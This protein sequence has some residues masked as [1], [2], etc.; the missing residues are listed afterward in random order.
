MRKEL[1]LPLLVSVVALCAGLGAAPAELEGRCKALAPRVEQD[2]AAFAER[3]QHSG[4]QPTVRELT[5]CAWGL[6]ELGRPPAGAEA[7]MRRAFALQDTDPASPRFGTVPWQEGHPEIQDANAIEFTMLPVGPILLR[8]GGRFSEK[9]NKET[10]VHVRAGLAAIRR[11]RV[12]P[13]YSNIYLMRMANLLLLGQSVGDTKAQAEGGAAFDTWLA[14]TRTNGVA[15]YDSPTYT[16]IQVDCLALAHHFT[17]NA[18]LR[19]RLQAALDFYWA[20][21]AGN[22]FAGRQTMTAP[23]SRDYNFLF[24][25]ENVNW[26]YYLAGL[27]SAEPGRVF[28]SDAVRLWATAHLDVY[29]GAPGLLEL[30]ALPERVVRSRFGVLPGQDRYVLITPDFAIGSASAY[31][32]PQDKRVCVELA[33]AKKLP[34]ISFLTDAFDAPF[35]RVRMTDRSGHRKP[36]HLQQIVATVQDRGFLLGLFDVSPELRRGEVTNL[37]SNIILPMQADQ[38]WLDGR[39]VDTSKR[40]ALPAGPDSVVAV[41][42][43]KAAVAARLFAADGCAGRAPLWQLKY[44]GNPQGAGRFVV[45]HYRGSPRQLVEPAVRAGLLLVA[46]RCETDAEFAVFLQRARQIQPVSRLDNDVWQVSARLGA[47]E[48]Q[49][50]LD[51]KQKKIAARRVNGKAWQAEVLNVNGRDFLAETLGSVPAHR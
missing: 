50:A 29:R 49:A 27:R 30:A 40:V 9:F 32:G 4:A 15:E 23:A 33:S 51:L 31:Y 3:M 28:L 36:R 5:A 42:E 37:A 17:T 2:C 11:H 21:L 14:F 12:R 35:G 20:D 47:T 22:Y 1:R 46:E 24:S 39:R 44:D 19:P 13:S 10:V 6:L 16:P 43:G 45:Y 38:V 8:H 34:V 18:A 48:L 41:R 25:D 26:T 7:L